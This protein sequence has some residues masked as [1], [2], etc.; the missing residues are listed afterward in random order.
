MNAAIKACIFLTLSF[1]ILAGCEVTEEKI[2]LWKGTQNGP[3]KLAGTVI[4]TEIELGLRAKA[5]VALV[6]I[7][8]WDLFREAFKKM[9]KSDA[10]RIVETVAPIL[11]KMVEGQGSTKEKPVS[12]LQVD[13]KDGLFILLDYAEGKGKAEAEQALINWCIEDYNVR[14]MA[15]QYNIRTIVKKVGPAAADALI[16]LLAV[17]QLVIKHVAELV[18]QVKDETVLAKASKHLADNLNANIKQIQ[19]AHLVSAAIIGGSPIA[20]MLLGLSTNNEVSGELQRFALRAFSESVNT[21]SVKLGDPQINTL[22][23]MA[24]NTDFDKF[25]REETYYVIAQAGRKDDLPRFRKLLSEKSSFWRAVGLRCILRIDGE[26]QLASVLQE[27]AR[28]KMSKNKKDVEEVIS[29]IA[30]F[31]KLL[32]KI[33]KLVDNTNPFVSAVAVSVLGQIGTK[34]DIK[35]LINFIGKKTKLSKGFEHKTLGLT[36]QAAVEAIKKRG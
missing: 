9:E 33:R 30:S 21:G 12:K 17:N 10:Q 36:A 1:F 25:Q 20:D 26:G 24:E 8:A 4:D 19:E 13:A 35:K 6:E 5:T 16:P 15:G 28:L 3:K 14:A 7:N 27:I 18:R 29:R 31:P 2:N 22:F 23:G 32:P 11:S 34:D